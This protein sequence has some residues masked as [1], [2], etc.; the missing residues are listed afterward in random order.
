MRSGRILQ[1]INRFLP[2]E[3]QSRGSSGR[4]ECF[5]ACSW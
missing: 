5:F 3:S 2:R 1:K 4:G